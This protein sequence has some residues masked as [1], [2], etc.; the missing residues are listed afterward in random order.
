[1]PGNPIVYPACAWFVC[2]SLKDCLAIVKNKVIFAYAEITQSGKF[3]VNF[4]MVLKPR[5]SDML[6]VAKR[7]KLV[8]ANP[9]SIKDV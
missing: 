6:R 3:V 1:M 8:V 7:I 5:Y 9:G 4:V 2:Q